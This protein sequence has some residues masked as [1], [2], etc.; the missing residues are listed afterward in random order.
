MEESIRI[1]EERPIVAKG[2]VVIEGLPDVGLVGTIAASFLVEQLS[3]EEVAS[4]ESDLLPPVMVIH[5]GVLSNPLRIFGNDRMLV[6]TSQIALP[7]PTLYPLSRVLADWFV[8]K[9]AR[10]TVSLT[11]FPVEDRANIES[12]SV[13]GVAGNKEGGDVLGKAGI[14]PMAEGFVAGLYALLLKECSRRSLPSIALIS[15]SFLNYPDPGAAAAVVTAVDKILNLKI[16]VKPLLEKG[17]EIRIKARDLMRQAQGTI[18][19]VKQVEQEMP[20]IYK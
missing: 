7:P 5:E 4:V 12:P 18:G 11:G 2:P 20:L 6:V 3:L 19:Q 15:Q 1:I 9:K 10:L 16:D 13:F 17:D 14:E 8:S